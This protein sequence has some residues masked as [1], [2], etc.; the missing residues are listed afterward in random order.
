M[1]L[2]GGVVLGTEVIGV[3]TGGSRIFNWARRC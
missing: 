3:I 1:S 2:Y